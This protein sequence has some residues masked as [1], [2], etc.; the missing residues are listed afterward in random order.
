MTAQDIADAVSIDMR[1]L[2]SNT[3]PDL[4]VIV[5]WI[6]RVHKQVLHSSV[7]AAFNIAQ[8]TISTVAST[9]NYTLPS[10][11]RRIRTVYNRTLSQLILPLEPAAEPAATMEHTTPAIG[12]PQ[13]PDAKILTL[14][15]HGPFPL[16]YQRV[17]GELILFPQPRL[18]GNKIEV[19]YEKIV[20]TITS[21]ST[22]LTVPDD[23]KDIMVAGVNAL[24][25]LYLKRNDEA[26][27][28]YAMYQKLLGGET[29]V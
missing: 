3:D 23:G 1:R 15:V 20:P 24:V 4:S 7:Y 11:V 28:W 18:A 22:I 14:R 5:G 6:D 8:T 2:I 26:Q 21:A 13:A 25:A 17:G 29:Q 9:T 10:D 12:G 19:T 27:Q 16:Y